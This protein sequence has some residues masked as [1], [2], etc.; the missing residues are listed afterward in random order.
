MHCELVVP[1][2]FAAREIPRLPALE[3]LLARGRAT[4]ADPLSLEAWLA[5]QFG[6]GEEALPAGAITAQA[7]EPRDAGAA[8]V[9][10]DP[11]HLRL[12][13]D[14][15]KLIPGAAC[16]ISLEEAD[17]YLA[18]LNRHFEDR[19]FFTRARADQW[20][21]RTD[22]ESTLATPPPLEL[23]GLEVDAA[24]PGGRWNALLNE[25]QMA[26]HEHPLNTERELRGAP[27]ENSV[28]LWGAG[29]LPDTVGGPWHSLTSDDALGA[30]FAQLAGIRHR[31][32]P[33]TA[34]EWLDRAPEEGRHLIVL[35]A[36][37]GVLVLGGASE[38][39]DRLAALEAHWFAPLL[40]AL[41]RDRIGMVSV[42]APESGHS[43]ETIRGDL[44]R[45]WR[46]ARPLAA[47]T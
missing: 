15:A 40:E 24:L 43:C 19:Y 12:E 27:P 17:A 10:S 14:R 36:L 25:I 47:Y 7:T 28:W 45:F 42:H 39:A 33:G 30:G 11:I 6:L 22:D 32:L 1:A 41:R 31:G 16:A 34:G 13:R 3:L 29:R 21:A 4:Q 2:L 46:R 44:R 35:D 23:A 18:A 37:R 8:W 5:G 20:C 26:L 38:H 9:R